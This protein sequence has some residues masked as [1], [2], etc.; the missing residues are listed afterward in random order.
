MSPVKYRRGTALIETAMLIP[1]I[2]LLLTG[3]ATLARMT[4]TYY[5]LRKTVYSIARYAGT[6][7]AV[8]FCDANDPAVAAAIN[9]GMTGTTDGSQ[10]VFL[11]GLTAAMFQIAPDQLDG[12]C[13]CGVPGCDISQG[14]SAPDFIVVSMPDGYQMPVRI[15]GINIDPILM[16]PRVKVP[17][18][19]T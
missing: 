18:G 13:P 17:Y 16:K 14:G 6:Q 2:V 15:L 8:N 9:F 12:P 4:Y 1:L 5:T 11:T 19:G 10:P 7:Q 3:M